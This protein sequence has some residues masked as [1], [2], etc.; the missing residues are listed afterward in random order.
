M[1][2]L[3]MAPPHAAVDEPPMV[4]G[5]LSAD[6]VVAVMMGLGLHPVFMFDGEERRSNENRRSAT[7][8][9]GDRDWKVMTGA[10]ACHGDSVW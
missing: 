10:T 1:T 6:V 2:S 7:D 8:R 9:R 5:G 3:V 4:C